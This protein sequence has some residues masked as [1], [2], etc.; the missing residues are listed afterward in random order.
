VRCTDIRTNID[1]F[2]QNVAEKECVYCAERTEHSGKM[3]VNIG[4]PKFIGAN[5]LT[6]RLILS[7]NLRGALLHV[8]FVEDEVTVLMFLSPT[9]IPFTPPIAIQHYFIALTTQQTLTPRST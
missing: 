4:V 3:A 6:Y 5:D 8:R 1:R 2:R 7:K 9:A